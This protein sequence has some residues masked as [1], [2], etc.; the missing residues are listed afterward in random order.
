MPGDHNI[1]TEWFTANDLVYQLFKH[2]NDIPI[3]EVIQGHGLVLGVMALG[4]TT[5]LCPEKLSNKIIEK[6]TSMHTISLWVITGVLLLILWKV[7][8][9]APQPFIY[10]Q[11]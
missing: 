1:L 3:F 7:G 8:A 4:F 11:F 9:S 6:F 10:F 2:F 5:H